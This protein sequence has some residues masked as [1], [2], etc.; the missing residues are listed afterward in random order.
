MTTSASASSWSRAS[1]TRSA[2]RRF[3][4]H[5]SAS[6]IRIPGV[7][8]KVLHKFVAVARHRRHGHRHLPARRLHPRRHPPRAVVPLDRLL[9]ARLERHGPSAQEAR[10]RSP[11]I[12]IR[13]SRQ[14]SARVPSRPHLTLRVSQPLILRAGDMQDIQTISARRR[15]AAPLPELRAVG[16]HLARAARRARRPQAGAAPHPVRDVPR[17]APHA[18][19][20]S[21]A[22]APRSSAT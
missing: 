14:T 6:D 21:T 22:S 8:D 3:H 9:A 1:A 17:P 4:F 11:N 10:S 13:S 15:G 20:A 5:G 19:R 7:S 18:R 16:H 12:V 2:P